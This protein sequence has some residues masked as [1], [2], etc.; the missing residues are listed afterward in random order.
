[1]KHRFSKLNR[2]VHAA[3]YQACLH[4][5]PHRK[6]TCLQ[7]AHARQSAISDANSRICKSGHYEAWLRTWLCMKTP[8]VSGFLILALVEGAGRDCSCFSKAIFD[9]CCSERM[10]QSQ[11]ATQCKPNR[12]PACFRT[13][14]GSL[15]TIQARYEGQFH[16]PDMTKDAQCL[17]KQ[18]LMP[19]CRRFVR[20]PAD[21]YDHPLELRM[22]CLQV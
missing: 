15:L 16:I 19:S 7:P 12:V 6:P 20:A 2:C 22:Q 14:P 4:L 8:S 3:Y 13:D 9:L 17:S 18:H 11:V 21:Y 5:V 10:R 1:M